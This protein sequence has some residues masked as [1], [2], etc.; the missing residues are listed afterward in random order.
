M[1]IALCPPVSEELCEQVRRTAPGSE[2][3]MY[4]LDEA[5]PEMGDVEIIFGMFN[6]EMVRAAENLKWIQTTSAGMDMFMK[7]TEVQEGDFRLCNASGI[8]AIQVAEHAWALTTALFRGL[9]VFLQN[10][11]KR[12][13]TRAP[14]EDL[15]GATAGIIGFGGI[16]N[17]F[18]KRAQ[19]SEM[20]ILAVDIQGGEKPD[21][22]EALW[23]I[24][25]LDDLLKESDLVFI[26]CPWTPETDKLINA[27][28]LGLMKESAFLVN[29]ARGPIVDETALVEALET[30]AI[31]GAGLDVFEKEPLPEE[32]PLWA[33]DNTIITTHAAGG[34]HYRPQRTVD[35]FCDNLK[36]YIAGE[37]LLNEMDR[38]LGYPKLESR[39]Q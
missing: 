17:E 19:A 22:V 25:R 37:P 15:Y 29:T 33:M 6:V 30:N 3:V 36:R 18:A 31:A 24:E 7:L 28:T 20:R 12:K 8:H 4:S 5:A 32:S 13:W 21:Y 35:F 14:M 16:G 1:K 11:G 27:R 34:S 10:Q 26:A 39:V 23:G 2:V 38:K 9:H